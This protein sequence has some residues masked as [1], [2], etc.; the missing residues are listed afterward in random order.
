MARKRKNDD[1]EFIITFDD[2]TTDFMTIDRYTLASGDHVA[3]I[4]AG[5]RQS[6]GPIPNKPIKSVRRA[7]LF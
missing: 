6:G 3:R 2:D 7:P 5:E 4:I 1:V